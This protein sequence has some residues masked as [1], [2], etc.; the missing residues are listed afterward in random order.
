MA[1]VSDELPGRRPS[2][3]DPPQG[4]QRER[5][6]AK[7]QD[8][9][10][11][12]LHDDAEEAALSVGVDVHLVQERDQRLLAEQVDGADPD[13]H[14]HAHGDGSTIPEPV[15]I[16]GLQT[17][18]GQ[19]DKVTDERGEEDRLLVQEHPANDHAGDKEPLQ[20]LAQSLRMGKRR[21]RVQQQYRQQ[22]HRL[23]V[24][25]KEVIDVARRQHHRKR[26]R[27]KDIDAVEVSLEEVENQ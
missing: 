6:Y 24:V 9:A 8:L 11:D 25:S 4:E 19:T 5:P 20:L 26:A 7:T 12:A 3:V 2:V 10:V 18:R 13:R 15:F 23:V 22:C 16:P 14:Q 27:D 17:K 21:G 1:S